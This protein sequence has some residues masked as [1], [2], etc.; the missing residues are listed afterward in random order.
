MSSCN[1]LQLK[2]ICTFLNKEFND[3]NERIDDSREPLTG[4]LLKWRV[5]TWF[6][7]AKTINIS[8]V[9]FEGDAASK[10][11]VDYSWNIITEHFAAPGW[12]T[13]GDDKEGGSGQIEII[14]ICTGGHVFIVNSTLKHIGNNHFSGRS[15]VSSLLGL[16]GRQI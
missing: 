5:R 14:A 6:S 16:N 12:K 13:S 10:I 1:I 11:E 4:T 8:D 2:S 15:I 9:N 3:G 7:T